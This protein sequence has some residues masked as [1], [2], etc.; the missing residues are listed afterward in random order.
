MHLLY[1]DES[2][3]INGWNT[4]KNFVLGG[5]S[6][7]EGQ[8]YSLT[9]DLNDLQDEYFPGYQI[10]IEFHVSAIRSRKGPHFNGLSKDERA[11]VIEKIYDIL[12]KRRF[13]NV[14]VFGTGIHISAVQNAGQ[15]CQT[16]FED[17]CQNF[18]R[19]LYSGMKIAQ[20]KK[21]SFSKG[22]LIIDRGRE[23]RY[24]QH[25]AEFRAEA[26]AQKYLANIVDIPYFSA[27]AETRMLQLADFI[28]NALWRYFEKGITHEYD[29]IKHLFYRGP[30]AFPVPGFN[31]IIDETCSCDACEFKKANGIT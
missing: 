10:P 26:D 7:F 13:P 21:K 4:Q 5:I 24:R 30:A 20:M 16:C 29:K 22:M 1:L 9:K 14:V 25:F 15:V 28:S 8:I 18:N 17:V 11:E 6:V 31:H 23:K 3:D 12:Q 2:G 19:F 27:C